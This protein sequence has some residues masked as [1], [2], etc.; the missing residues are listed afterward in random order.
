ME[1]QRENE[2]IFNH[3]DWTF[4]DQKDLQK[5]YK[6]ME[7]LYTQIAEGIDAWFVF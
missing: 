1:L 4:T 2:L 7:K 3:N 5:K 6:K